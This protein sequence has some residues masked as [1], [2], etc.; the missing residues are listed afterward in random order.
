MLMPKNRAFNPREGFLSWMRYRVG[1]R[2]DPAQARRGILDRCFQQTVPDH[3]HAADT[4]GAPGTPERAC[5]MVRTLSALCELRERDDPVKNREAIDDYRE[6]I[7]Y[8]R[9][10]YMRFLP[11]GDIPVIP[12]D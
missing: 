9:S 3:V 11:D 12:G 5:K 8:L 1:Q 10:R 7:R 6:D 2:G 4:W